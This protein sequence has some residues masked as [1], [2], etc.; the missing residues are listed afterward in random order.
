MRAMTALIVLA[1][2]SQAASA[3][4]WQAQPDT[5]P[6]SGYINHHAA[7]TAT[8]EVATLIL[9]CNV[10]MLDRT[11]ALTVTLA[12]AYGV[13]DTHDGSTEFTLNWRVDSGQDHQDQVHAFEDPRR[14]RVAAQSSPNTFSPTIAGW[15]TPPRQL[16][17]AL[18]DTLPH[19]LVMRWPVYGEGEH[20]V[21][22][23][24]MANAT[25]Q[26]VVQE[27]AMAGRD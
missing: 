24:L 25:V 26:A 10:S 20:T 11:P 2:M 22:W 23:H 5:F 19:T 14:G 9:L 7:V 13:F 15:L 16:L 18:L 27:C 17:A 3:Q 1:L 12:I 6:R 21:T 4:T 8:A